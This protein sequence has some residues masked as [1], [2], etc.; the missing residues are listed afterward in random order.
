MLIF[1]ELLALCTFVMQFKMQNSKT[2]YYN[3]YIFAIKL[4]SIII[5]CFLF[6]C[7]DK[8][9]TQQVLSTESELQVS[10]SAININIA[11]A[12]ELERL[13][14]I[15]EKLALQ[16]VEHRERYGR[17]RKPE[18]L[19]LVRGISNQRFREIRSFIKVK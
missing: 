3:T 2:N 14:H 6:A 7:S 16:I 9:E 13:P 12:E 15:G 4:V 10:E 11:A 5:C 18:Y 8:K 1:K 19:L 17:F